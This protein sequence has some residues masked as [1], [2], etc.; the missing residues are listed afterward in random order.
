MGFPCEIE[1]LL[2]R[3]PSAP[4]RESVG[5][6]NARAVCVLGRFRLAESMQ[7]WAFA[8]PRQTCL[9]SIAPISQPWNKPGGVGGLP[10]S[11]VWRRCACAPSLPALT[12]INCLDGI[13][14]SECS[15][16]HI[17]NVIQKQTT[18]PLQ[19]ASPRLRASEFICHIM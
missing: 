6:S 12:P 16:F 10:P 2:R 11:C 13:R 9:R 5:P 4:A 18:P 1:H 15:S 7:A 3:E 8:T 19:R 14:L 17:R